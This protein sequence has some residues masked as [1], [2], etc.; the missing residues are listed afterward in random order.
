MLTLIWGTDRE[1]TLKALQKLVRA[2][3]KTPLTVND[4]HTL[5]DL[6]ASLQGGGLFG[7]V[8][9]VVLDGVCVNPEMKTE[10]LASLSAMKKAKDHFVLREE[11]LDADTRKQI[12]KYAETSD[13]HELKKEKTETTI[14]ALASA[15]QKRDKKALWV[16]LQ[17]EFL[18]GNAPEAVHG[19]LFWGAK[20]A[21][22]R[23]PT[24]YTK[25]LV[26]RLAE[27]PHEARRRGME[28]DYALERFALS[29]V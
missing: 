18:S 9:T 23:A 28:L 8:R 16:G 1:A 7:D 13:K 24:S 6:R 5:D 25:T 10:V 15:L 2:E 19:V 29:E 3:K 12:E 11:K 17:R 26:E 27:L 21:H 22:L 4:A 14:F 20:Q